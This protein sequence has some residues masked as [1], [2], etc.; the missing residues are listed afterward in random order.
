MAAGNPRAIQGLQVPAMLVKHLV[1]SAIF[2]GALIA[3]QS[4]AAE[5]QKEAG[6]SL[7]TY[8]TDN[9]CLSD[10]DKQGRMAGTATPDIYLQGH[11]ARANLSLQAA[12]EFNSLGDSN[13]DCN[14]GQLSNRQSLI[15]SLRFAGDLEPID[16]WL[17]LEA[18]AFVGRNPIDAFAASGVDNLSGR[19]NLNITYQYGA[20][21]ILQRR[22]LE[23]TQMRLRYHYDQQSN[24]VDQFGDSSEDLVEFDLDTD[25]AS[26]RLSTGIGGRHSKVTF[27]ASDQSPAFD[28]TLSSANIKTALQF[29]SSWQVNALVGHEWNEFTSARDDIDGAYWDAALRWTPNSRVEIEVGT[30]ER[31]FGTTPRLDAHYRHKR[32]EF[33]VS[34]SRTLTFPRNLRAASTG[35]DDPRNSGFDPNSDSDFGQFPSDPLAV[36]GQ[37]TFSGNT[38][39]I[40]EHLAVSYRFTGRRTTIRVSAS[41]SRQLRIE[42]SGEADFT[43]VG[44]TFSRALSSQ[45]SMHAH[46]GWSEREGRG[47]NTESINGNPFDQS[48]R[49]WRAG[50]GFS[51]RLGANTTV[52]FGYQFTHQVSDIAV[53]EYDENRVTLSIR[54]TF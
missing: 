48:S 13:Q 31:F 40:N 25:P 50:T 35:A 27:E 23:N 38:P 26:S 20:G 1:T 49:T 33:T 3:T 6:I 47:L 4:L 34:Y 29:N 39:I 43:D 10:V 36:S 45:I 14:S 30:G 19:D 28:N 46:L 54:R 53:N 9:A 17:T 11:G 2:S 8:Y 51:R 12:V 32:S 44:V 52:S 41:D 42:D 22:L 18:D 24:E 37:P 5:W 16:D 7:G 21:A 15:P